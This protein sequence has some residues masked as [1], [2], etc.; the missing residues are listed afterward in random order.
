[1]N[2]GQFASG[3]CTVFW[4]RSKP[5]RNIHFVTVKIT[6]RVQESFVEAYGVTQ[7]ELRCWRAKDESPAGMFARDEAAKPAPN[8]NR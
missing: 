7:S 3:R 8:A 1:M 4:R 6:G 2:A 5:W